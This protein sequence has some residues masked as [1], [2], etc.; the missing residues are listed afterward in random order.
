MSYPNIKMLFTLMTFI[1]S[2]RPYSFFFIF[3]ESSVGSSSYHRYP[4]C[5]HVGSRHHCTQHVRHAGNERS[6]PKASQFPTAICLRWS[7]N[8]THSLGPVSTSHCST[9]IPTAHLSRAS[10]CWASRSHDQSFPVG[11]VPCNG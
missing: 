11:C 7:T 10:S 9:F 6:S 8:T 3:R 2:K 4:C 5:R 1:A